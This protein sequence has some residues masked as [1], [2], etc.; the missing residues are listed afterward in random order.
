[1]VVVSI[2]ITYYLMSFVLQAVMFS[3]LWLMIGRNVVGSFVA[4]GQLSGLQNV[5]SDLHYYMT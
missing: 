4:L 5:L 1:M 3:F 2:A